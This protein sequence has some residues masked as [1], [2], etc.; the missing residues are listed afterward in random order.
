VT[1]ET[2]QS[3]FANHGCAAQAIAAYAIRRYLTGAAPCR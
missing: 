2:V 3:V 1:D